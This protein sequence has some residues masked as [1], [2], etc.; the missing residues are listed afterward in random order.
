M[1]KE[2]ELSK[3]NKLSR[4]DFLLNLVLGSGGLFFMASCSAKNFLNVAPINSLDK[5]AFFKTTDDLVTGVNGVYSSQQGLFNSYL[6]FEMQEIRSDNARISMTSDYPIDLF[7]TLPGSNV[8]LDIWSNMYNVINLA[9]AVIETG[10][11]VSGDK[12]L[13]SR[14]VGE[15]KFLRAMTYFEIVNLWG[16]V[17]LRINPT[18]NFNNVVVPTSPSSKIYTQMIQDLNDA[19]SVLPT[20]YDG[21]LNN[22]PG[23]AT[24]Y[25]AMTMLGKV[26]LQSGDKSNAKAA[27]SQVI[28]KY[29]LLPNYKDI[30]APGNKNS[31]ESIFE[32]SYNPANH[33]GLGLNNMFIPHEEAV[34]LGILAGGYSPQFIFPTQDLIDSFES[35]D[36]RKDASIS[37]DQ[38]SG[39]PYISKFIDLNAVSN[40]SNID[41]VQLRY[42]D[43]LLM[44]AEATGESSESYG[45][46]NQVRNRAGLGPISSSTPGTFIDKVQHE[47]RV[48][49]AFEQHRW[50]D[51]LR[52][53]QSEVISIMSNQLTKQTG[54]SVSLNKNDLLYPIPTYEIQISD[55]KVTQNPGY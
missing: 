8:V 10:P 14:V 17:P 41:L 25:A 20:S 15:A 24:K 27:L 7:S 50:F 1:S 52:L 22:E 30:Y 36:L 45:Y 46:I 3:N 34:R 9:N 6:T 35:G 47:R 37:I 55:G 4:R 19:A 53:P 13:A 44:L 32:I 26:Y 48:E 28:N 21:S 16:D 54:K 2:N 42:A 11:K 5:P 23:R 43:V 29:S 38:T 40:G 12:N 18:D 33:T 31:A 39:D 49:F 51:L